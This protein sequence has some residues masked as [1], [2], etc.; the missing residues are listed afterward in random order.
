MSATVRPISSET[1]M[2][3]RLHKGQV[4]RFRCEAMGR[5]MGSPSEKGCVLMD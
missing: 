1:D 3:A 2:M 5:F 4:A